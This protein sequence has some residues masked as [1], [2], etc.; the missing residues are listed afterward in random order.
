MKLSDLRHDF[1]KYGLDETKSPGSPILMFRSWIEKAKENGV[2]EFNAMVL[3]TVGKHNRPSSRIV[4]LKEIME[5]GA[6]VFYTNYHSKKGRD[7]LN[8]PFGALHFFWPELE[9]QIRIEG[10]VAKTHSDISDDYFNSRP[11][12]SKAS[13]IVS[14]QSEKI[15]N[16]TALKDSS[17][18]LI[19]NPHKIKRP[20]HWGGYELTPDLFEFWQGGKYRLHDRIRYSLEGDQWIKARLAP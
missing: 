6:L 14:P 10:T 1:G 15:D 19:R 11:V 3:S 16:L 12:E 8:N 4:L 2:K 17:R 20:E 9:R 18:F 5:S 7:L 13:A